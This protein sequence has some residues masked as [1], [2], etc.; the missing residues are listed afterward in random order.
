MVCYV[1]ERFHFDFKGAGGVKSHLS[2]PPS[3]MCHWQ[4]FQKQ[5]VV[6]KTVAC[7]HSALGLIH[8]LVVRH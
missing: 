3:L 6:P 5:T 4:S 2:G 1:T 7:M 8:V